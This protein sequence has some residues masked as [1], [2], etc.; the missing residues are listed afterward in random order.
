MNESLCNVN[1]VKF[2]ILRSNNWD[3]GPSVCTDQCGTE[4]G[5]VTVV[6]VLWHV[7]VLY[8]EASFESWDLTWDGVAFDRIYIPVWKD[9]VVGCEVWLIPYF[10][11]IQ[12]P[13]DI[14]FLL[15]I[16]Y[17]EGS[18]V[19]GHCSALVCWI[20]LKHINTVK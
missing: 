11:T 13:Q 15:S 17:P 1:V 2:Q 8:D 4:G 18:E 12:F 6:D 9:V 3:D 19:R 20:W 7:E 5:T 10:E 14:P 16:G